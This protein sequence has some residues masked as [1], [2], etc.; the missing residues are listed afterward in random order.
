LPGCPGSSCSCWAA[1]PAG[2]L[3]YWIANNTITFVQQYIIMRS[4][5][6]KPDLFGNIRSSFQRKKTEGK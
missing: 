5:G 3:V 4:H 2:L 1:S 6:Y